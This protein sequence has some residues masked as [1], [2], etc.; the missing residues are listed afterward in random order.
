MGNVGYDKK[1][2]GD[3]M[4]KDVPPQTAPHRNIEIDLMKGLL[5]VGMILDHSIQFI[6]EKSFVMTG[7]A[8]LVNLASF[9]GFLFCF[10]YANW[11][12]Y[13]T[14]P[15]LPWPRIL[16]TAFKCYVAFV[17]SGLCYRF[18]VDKYPA[19]PKTL[20]NVIFLNDIP[21]YSEFLISFSLI[22]LFA[23][24]L[25]PVLRLFCASA[26][27]ALAL[28]AV[29]GLTTFLPHKI[30]YPP[31]IGLFLGGTG[32]SYFPV[33]QYFPLFLG[34]V[35]FARHRMQFNARWLAFGLAGTAGFMLL[36][37]TKHGP[38][39]FPPSLLWIVCSMGIV[40]LYGVL[41][42]GIASRMHGFPLKYLN[43]VGNNVL[44]YLLI[45]NLVFFTAHNL[46]IVH[47][48]SAAK[49]IGFDLVLLLVLLYFQSIVVDLTRSNRSLSPPRGTESQ[50]IKP[51]PRMREPS[52]DLGVIRRQS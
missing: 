36:A 7:L 41:A 18:L 44:F 21:G 11:A 22:T 45:S 16:Q 38:S 46:G 34:G 10:G 50:T 15:M 3:V 32:F 31:Q 42:R 27:A 5:T 35:F 13:L 17:I 37:L 4:T 24:L 23:A 40:S 14:K 28:S 20:W 6:S 25:A 12:A 30:G 1:T 52:T 2:P 48:L 9:S 8:Q 47:T 51:P 43:A 33:L 19:D 39:R 29:F 49:T 26:G